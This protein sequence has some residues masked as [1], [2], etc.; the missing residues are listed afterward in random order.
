[1]NRRIIVL[2]QLLFALALVAASSFAADNETLKKDLTAVIALQGLPCGEVVNV[3]VHAESDFA[4]TCKDANKYRVYLNDAGRVV[5][6]KQ[7]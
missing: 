3:I 4:V 1:M 7:K 2:A 5:V 6:D